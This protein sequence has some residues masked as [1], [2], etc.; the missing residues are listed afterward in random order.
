MGVLTQWLATWTHY[1]NENSSPP[2]DRAVS[3][4]EPLFIFIVFYLCPQVLVCLVLTG[5]LYSRTEWQSLLRV[6]YAN[7]GLPTEQKQE[8]TLLAPSRR[9]WQDLRPCGAM[10]SQFVQVI[11]SWWNKNNK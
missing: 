8:G 3:A 2:H 10:V 9:L 5:V 6:C 7:C 11:Y 1:T 4:F